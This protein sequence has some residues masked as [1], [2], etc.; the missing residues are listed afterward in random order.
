MARSG[1]LILCG[2]FRGVSSQDWSFSN[3]EPNEI[4]SCVFSFILFELGQRRRCEH[5]QYVGLCTFAVENEV[6]FVSVNNSVFSFRPASW[7]SYGTDGRPRKP[8][9]KKHS[10]LFLVP[11]QAR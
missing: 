1:A 2:L 3:F 9:W 5:V 4:A 6:I 10:V 8:K 7:A 11:L